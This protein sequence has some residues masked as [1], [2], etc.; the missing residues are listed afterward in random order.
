[1]SQDFIDPISEFEQSVCIERLEL[2]CFHFHST[3]RI[4]DPQDA[5]DGKIRVFKGRK[6]NRRLIRQVKSLI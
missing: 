3:L 1:M 6:P 2:L 5:F 4:A